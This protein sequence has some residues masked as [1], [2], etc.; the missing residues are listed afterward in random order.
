MSGEAGYTMTNI[1]LWPSSVIIPYSFVSNGDCFKNEAVYTDSKIGLSKEELV[2]IM[3]AM[4]KIEDMTCIRFKRVKPEP[5]Q[6]WLLLM[7]EGDGHQ[8]YISYIERTLSNKNIKGLGQIF[9]SHWDY[10]TR[11]FPGFYT[12]WLGTGA[13]TYLVS[14]LVDI[15]DTEDFVGS[16]V[17]E[18]F[19]TLGV[20][21]TQKRPDRDSYI[22]VNK[23]NILPDQ[24]S[25]YEKCTKYCETHGFLYDCES[26]MHYRDTAFSNG[27]GKTMTAKNPY[28]CDLSRAVTQMSNSDIKLL[29]VSFRKYLGI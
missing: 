28:S 23:Q 15:R 12:T 7:K 20:G 14:S 25:Q 27:A 1:E 26:I 10:R 18:L 6:N 8:C 19:H 3:K 13:P 16:Y 22:T 4:R 17:H 2:V 24:S 21:H 29:N 11:C 5:D 9:S